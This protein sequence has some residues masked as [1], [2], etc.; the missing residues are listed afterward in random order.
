[1]RTLFE[2][3]CAEGLAL[4]TMSMGMSSDLEAAVL[5]GATMVRIG[6]AIFGKRDYSH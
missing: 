6:T 2:T 5:E 3:L 4:D 1:M